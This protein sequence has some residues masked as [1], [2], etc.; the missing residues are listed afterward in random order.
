MPKKK[1]EPIKDLKLNFTGKASVL[2][3]LEDYG[4]MQYR[5][6]DLDTV[7]KIIRVILDASNNTTTVDSYNAREQKTF[8]KILDNI[9]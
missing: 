8:T 9:E 4:P 7:I 6:N 3:E 5:I 2:V 1:T